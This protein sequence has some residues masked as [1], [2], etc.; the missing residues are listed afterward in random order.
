MSGIAGILNTQGLDEKSEIYLNKM[1]EKL[2][3]RGPDGT[4]KHID[5]ENGLFTGQT[6]LHINGAP[7]DQSPIFAERMADGSK[8]LACANARFYD[9]K[10]TRSE[11][12]LEGYD[13]H[14][15]N[16]HEIILHLYK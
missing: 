12:Q 2:R 8:L 15:K 13:F 14:S 1:L 5:R 9:F 4:F 7:A 16:D 3:H 11:L 6:Y 10:K